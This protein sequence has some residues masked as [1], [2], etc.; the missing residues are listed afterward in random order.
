M[1][2]AF[3]GANHSLLESALALMSRLQGRFQDLKHLRPVDPH[4]I[5]LFKGSQGS[6]GRCEGWRHFEGQS[7]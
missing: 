6:Q 5:G 4:T 1:P 3:T 7:L 2:I